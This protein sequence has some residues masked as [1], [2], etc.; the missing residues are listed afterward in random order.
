MRRCQRVIG[1]VRG[2][3]LIRHWSAIH[4]RIETLADRKVFDFHL[5]AL[6]LAGAGGVRM[7]FTAQSPVSVTTRNYFYIVCLLL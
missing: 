5:A 6:A 4:Q 1:C 2:C 7:G 3:V